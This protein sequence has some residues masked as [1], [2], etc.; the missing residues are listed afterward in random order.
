MKPERLELAEVDVPVALASRIQ[1]AV[2]A[3]LADPWRRYGWYRM[4]RDR[5]EP[6]I[7]VVLS[8]LLAGQAVLT[9][10]GA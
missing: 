10:L 2:A 7:V 8:T 3:E 4:W 9:A 5:V 6:A 1:R